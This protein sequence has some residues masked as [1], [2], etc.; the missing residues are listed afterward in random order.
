MLTSKEVL[1]KTGISRATL[2]NYISWGIVPRP[3]VLPP[4]PQDGA[5]PRIGYF[6]DDV[7]DRVEEIQRLKKQGWSIT[8]ITE[9]FGGQTPNVAASN[10]QTAS[11]T[12]P[13]AMEPRRGAMPGLSIDAIGHPAYL[14]NES[15]EVAWLNDAAQSAGGANVAP[16]PPEAVSQGI[17]KYLLGAP[18]QARS[19]ETLLRFHLGLAKQRGASLSRLSQHVPDAQLAT[20]ERLYNEAKPNQPGLVAQTSISTGSPGSAQVSVYALQFREGILFLYVPPGTASEEMSTLLSQR[21]RVIGEVRATR[22]PGLTHVAVLVTDLQHSARLWAELPPEEYF[23]LINHIWLTVD[24]IFRRHRG[25]HGKHPG[26]GMVCYFFPQ[27]DSS[28]LWNALVAAHQMRDTMRRVSKEWQLR[29]GWTTE[30]CL[31]AGI[32]EGQEWL[33]TFRSGAQSEYTVLGDAV[34]RAAHISNFSRSGAIW[35][36]RHLIVK[37]GDEERQRLKFGV[38]RRNKDGQDVFVSSTFSRVENLVDPASAWNQHLNAIARLPIAEIVDI[39]AH[40]NAST[41]SRNPN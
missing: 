31:N 16:L 11:G 29:K 9:H 41:A 12:P 5:A 27:P 24:P 6:P 3:E 32:D 20:L 10:P 30:L 1:E 4:E 28:Y 2:N 22:M 40:E 7:V 13:A 18:A 36:T 34:D 23:E 39:A 14:V 25:T 26:E 37:L 15:F 8:T 19:R 21:E 33:G 17:F 35:A 38:R